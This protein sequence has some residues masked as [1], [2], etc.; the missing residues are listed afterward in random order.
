M[1]SPLRGLALCVLLA[2]ALS[3]SGPRP[4]RAFGLEDVARQARE[5]AA[6]DYVEPRTL[7][8]WLLDVDYDAYRDIRF[9]PARALWRE[10]GLPFSVQFFHPGFLYNRA[11]RIS[12]V[13]PAG[14][15][16]PV[17]F[18]PE[19]FDYGKNEF[20][21]RVPQH[22]GYAGFRLH[23]PIKTASYQDEVAVFLGASYFRAVGRNLV[24]GL[25]A[26]GLAINTALPSGEE[27]PWFREFW[28]LQPRAGAKEFT[29]Y[30]LLDSPSTTGAYRFVVA[31][32]PRTRMDVELQ[33]FP[34]S[35][36]RKLGIAPLTSMFFRGEH[37]GDGRTPDYRPEVHDSDG[38]LLAAASG[39]WLWRPLA[40]PG[41]LR[42]TSFA[43]ENPRGFGLLQRD[44]DFDHYQDI[45]A[46][47]DL[48]SSVWVEPKGAWG[49]GRVEL[50][51]IPTRNENND[52]I[53]AY[54]VPREPVSAGK[55]VTFSYSIFWYGDERH[56]PP[57]GRTV[58]TRGDE[59]TYDGVRRLVL[60]FEGEALRRL[61]ADAVVEGVVTLGPVSGA[62]SPQPA[63]LLE[64]QVIRNP[65]TGGWRLVFQVAPPDDDPVELRA[66]L[67][68]GDDVLTETWSYLLVP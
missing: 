47:P 60:D 42:V 21:S 4:A 63:E 58:A 22:L 59:G 5:L 43:L 40:N 50:V 62:G 49:A 9:R 23:Y 35:D 27:F 10:L 34:R 18:S 37:A 48:R 51:E 67:R 2:A 12:V 8:G 15:V 57:G 46:R 28:L 20:G 6:R 30:A 7:P 31:P 14:S 68:R 56:W 26:R 29:F 54:W 17:A 65:V 13:D 1:R 44:R 45:E 66:F 52:N 32:G 3:A 61:P 16:S 53:V 36:L 25:S 11:V 33:L 39:E 19:Q 64:Q 41:D 24:Y 38:L 55:S